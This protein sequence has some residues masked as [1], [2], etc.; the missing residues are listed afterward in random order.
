MKEI[1]FSV[2]PYTIKAR[3]AVAQNN[4]IPSKFIS[5]FGQQL[6]QVNLESEVYNLIINGSD[7]FYFVPGI[8]LL[9]IYFL[10]EFVP[11]PELS[12]YLHEISRALTV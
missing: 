10:N 3:K 6:S 7:R 1:N 8:N 5:T 9:V 2:G 4:N 12:Q 11:Y